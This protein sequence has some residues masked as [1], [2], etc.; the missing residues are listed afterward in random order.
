MKKSIS[1][2]LVALAVIVVLLNVIAAIHAWKFTHYSAHGTPNEQLKLDAMTKAKLLFTGVDNPRPNLSCTPKPG[3][4]TIHIKSNVDLDCWM[5]KTNFKPK[6]TVILFHG[7]TANKC[8]L[9]PRAQPLLD[10]G[11]N[12]MLVDFMG[13]GG[14]GGNST[15]IGYHEAKEVTNCYKYL[16]QQ[17]EQR[18]FLLGSSMGAVAIMKA[19]NDDNIHPAGVILECPFAT[20]Y[21]TV[22]IRF[23]MMHVPT[24]PMAPLL[25][26]WGGVENGFWGFGHNPV[27]YASAIKCPVLL[28]YGAYDDRVARDE[29][30]RIKANLPENSKLVVYEQ[31]GH[32]DY[33][34]KCPT[35]WKSNVI[36][37]LNGSNARP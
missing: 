13:S 7:Y 25:V 37:F 23:K 28:Q 20:M 30:N 17:G 1:K 27:A 32:D 34:E 14:S 22:C 33:L 6:G 36:S 24:L 12:C 9:L 18:I 19:I 31:A 8:K 11:Y 5:L 2:W 26:F 21:E 35:E 15:S 3:T 4:A 10:S 16:Q 29:I